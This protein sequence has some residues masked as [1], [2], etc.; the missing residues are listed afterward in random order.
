MTRRNEY[1]D[2]LG[3]AFFESCPKTVLAAIAVSA[4]TIG[5]DLLDD[6]PALVA[7]EWAA[8]HAAG[9]VPQP[10]SAAARRTLPAEEVDPS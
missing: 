2:A 8:L 10:P 6:A 1:V 9:I 4:L 7:E 3:L 5:G